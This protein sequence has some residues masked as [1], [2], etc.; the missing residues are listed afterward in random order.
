MCVLSGECRCVM[1]VWT[2][3]TQRT[4]AQSNIAPLSKNVSAAGPPG[5]T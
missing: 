3:P 4:V 5:N 1:V 2:L